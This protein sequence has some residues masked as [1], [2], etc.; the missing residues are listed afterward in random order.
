MKIF[1]LTKDK[2]NKLHI[3]STDDAAIE[4]EE[5]RGREIIGKIETD[6]DILELKAYVSGNQ[7]RR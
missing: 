1:C 2:Y 6:L 3:C 4:W 5:S 7:E